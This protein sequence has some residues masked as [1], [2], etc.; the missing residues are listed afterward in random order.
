MIL[1]DVDNV[2]VGVDDIEDDK[3]EV[4]I[5][6]FETT[7]SNFVSNWGIDSNGLMIDDVST[8]I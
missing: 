4:D 6:W 5:W 3:G 8:G 7:V 1:L 2:K